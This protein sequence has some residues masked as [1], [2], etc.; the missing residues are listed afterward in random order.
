MVSGITA[1]SR[2]CSLIAVGTAALFLAS[3]GAIRT[4]PVSS[5]PN[6][7]L[8]PNPPKIYVAPFDTETAKWLIGRQ[9]PQLSDANNGEQID[10]KKSFQTKFSKILVE[11]LQ[12][13]APAEVRWLNDLPDEG[14]LVTG[15]FTTVYQGSRALRTLVGLGAG[16]TTFQTTVYVYDLSQSKDRYILTFNTGV[17]VEKKPSGQG[18]G[19]GPPPD[20]FSG[21]T[22]DCTRTARE[23][24]AILETYAKGKDG[25]KESDVTSAK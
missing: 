20:P 13:V 8:S 18:S 3:C 4:G 24:A 6:V 21:L 25:V 1:T 5:S 9:D 17:P 11:R 7:R 2:V 12:K 15:Q 22:S 23:I 14:W 16:E 10:F 19:E